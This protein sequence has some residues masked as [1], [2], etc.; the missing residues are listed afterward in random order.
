M[1]VTLKLQ[2]ALTA[3][4]APVH[5]SPEIEKS[6]ALVPERVTVLI[7]AEP[8]PVFVTT[9]V[10]GLPLVPTGWVGKVRLGGTRDKMGEPAAAAPVPV[11]KKDCGESAALSAT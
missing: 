2:V 1:K 11:T 9:M 4:V 10:C 5:V 8:V 7:V 3:T 6:E